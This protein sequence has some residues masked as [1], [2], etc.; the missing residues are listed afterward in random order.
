MQN[1][2]SILRNKRDIIVNRLKQDA[3]AKV[4]LTNPGLLLLSPYGHISLQ[5]FS[6]L[7]VETKGLHEIVLRYRKT[8]K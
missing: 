3:K 6:L 1:S 5:G 7:S 4:N 2:N 8:N